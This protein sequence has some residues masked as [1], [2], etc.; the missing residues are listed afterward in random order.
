M[1]ISLATIFPRF[2]QR[3]Q[4]PEPGARGCLFLV[5]MRAGLEAPCRGSTRDLSA[6]RV[7]GAEAVL[8]AITGDK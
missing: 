8:R 5:L 3:F 6:S 4:R 7:G 2:P 1:Y